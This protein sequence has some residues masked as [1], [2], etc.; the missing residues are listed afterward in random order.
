M[1]VVTFETRVS[2]MTT[3]EDIGKQIDLAKVYANAILLKRRKA[4]T[5]AETIAL[6]KKH[7]EALEV[8]R[9]LRLNYFELEDRLKVK[10]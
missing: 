10:T 9:K 3:V 1:A 7:K 8:V 4:E 2:K 6:D 5:L